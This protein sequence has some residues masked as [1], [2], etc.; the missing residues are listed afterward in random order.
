[1]EIATHKLKIL[2]Y[3]NKQLF[4]FKRYITSLKDCFDELED[5]GEGLTERQK[6][7]KLL[8]GMNLSNTELIAAQAIVCKKHPNDFIQAANALLVQITKM[9]P[10]LGATI[11]K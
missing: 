7:D 1:M 6:V 2:H 9:F 4:T 11:V 3:K 8:E 10:S 5:G